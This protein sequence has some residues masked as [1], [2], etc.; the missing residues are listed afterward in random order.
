MTNDQLPMTEWIDT[1]E[2]RWA[3]AHFTNQRGK[4]CGFAV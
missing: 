1:A 4:V 2:R 3:D